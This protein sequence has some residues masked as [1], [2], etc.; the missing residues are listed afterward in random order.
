M[1]V[2][3][4]SNFCASSPTALA[5]GVKIISRISPVCPPGKKMLLVPDGFC[6]NLATSPGPLFYL[7]YERILAPGNTTIYFIEA[8]PGPGVPMRE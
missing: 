4:P 3:K 7:G 6:L 8:Q 2:I 5:G 1:Y